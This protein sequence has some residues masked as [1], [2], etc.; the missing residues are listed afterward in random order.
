MSPE[1]SDK[2]NLSVSPPV[3]SV[4]CPECG[5]AV[6]YYDEVNSTH[7]VCPKCLVLFQVEDGTP[8]KRILHFKKQFR[9]QPALPI[10]CTGTFRGRTWR[11]LGALH[12]YE[13]KDQTARWLEYV[14]REEKTGAAAQLA[15]YNGHWTFIE[16]AKRSFEIER[17]QP[18]R[19]TTVTDSTDGTVYEIYHQY[20]PRLA[21]A[22]GE[23][24]WNPADDSTLNV[25]EFIAPPRMLV[26]E[27][28]PGEKKP[29]AWYRAEHADPD[30][31]AVAF[32][33]PRRTL[34]EQT[35]VGAIQPAPGDEHGGFLLKLAI[36]LA[37]LAI[38]VF[39]GLQILRPDKVLMSQQYTTEPELAPG[40]AVPVMTGAGLPI[41]SESFDVEG[42]T[43][44]SVVLIAEITNSWLEVGATMVNDQTGQTYEFVEAPEYYEGYDGGENWTEGDREVQATLGRIPT[45]RYHFN[46][47][48]YSDGGKSTKF[49]VIVMENTP[50]TSNLIV[51]LTII[52]TW[53]IIQMLRRRYHEQQRWYNSEFTPDE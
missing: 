6:G 27:A 8:T 49:R 3:D 25:W 41:V 51:V 48:P 1:P 10:G 53:P 43:A 17:A 47:S 7:F 19:D 23:F 40:L 28:A 45:G 18:A 37:A 13:A 29:G 24:D 34:G 4:T 22:V 15:V 46:F 16:A 12:R 9:V 52:L 36:G 2:T 31:L 20:S 26:G 11:V 32:G 42:P 38:V 33:V 50:L 5:G 30:E 35:G 39:L 44:L 14:L 21:A